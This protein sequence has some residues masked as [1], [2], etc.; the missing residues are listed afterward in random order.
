[1][2]T[3]PARWWESPMKQ[4]TGW[5]ATSRTWGFC[6]KL[7]ASSGGAYFATTPI[8]RYLNDRGSSARG[9][10]GQNVRFVISWLQNPTK[11]SAVPVRHRARAGLAVGAVGVDV[12]D[13]EQRVVGGVGGGLDAI[14][15]AGQAIDQGADGG[16][17]QALGAD[18]LDRGGGRAAGGDG[19]LYHQAAH[20]G[21][22]RALDPA[23]QAVLLAGAA[24]AVP[25]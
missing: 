3:G 9:T 10:R 5:L 23:L 22:D 18:A 2:S 12:V 21:F 11:F 20:A 19:V 7:L 16:D 13:G 4:P 14:G 25:A 15:A 6:V 1:M 24:I 8:W 17:L